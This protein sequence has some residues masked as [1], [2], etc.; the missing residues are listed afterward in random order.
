MTLLAIDPGRS[1]KASIGWCV[2][3]D[4]GSEYTRGELTWDGLVRSLFVRGVD[5]EDDIG[6]G[7]LWFS[8]MRYGGYRVN[9]VV[10]EN[11]VN[12]LK[13]RGGQTNG[14]SEVIGA[15]EIL[16]TQAG[17]PFFRQSPSILPIA[18]KF[19]QYELP[20]NPRTKKPVSH[21][22]HQDSAYLHGY[23]Y[24]AYEGV[25]QPKGLAGTI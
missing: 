12:N 25:L 22:P 11:F 13:S 6:L 14:A 7:Q 9:E 21:L 16:A 8:P 2:F 17:V 3:R 4:D 23:Y 19:A 10:V 24:L 20:V 5:D 15:I 18:M 1:V